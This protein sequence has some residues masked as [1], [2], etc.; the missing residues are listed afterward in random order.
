MRSVR[1][2][3][4]MKEIDFV[5]PDMDW[6][7]EI[8]ERKNLPLRCSFANVH[9]C[10]RYYSSLYLLGEAHITTKMEVKKIKELDR[11]WNR[12]SD[13]LPVIAEHDTGIT[14]SGDKTL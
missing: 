5:Y 4:D 7:S 9:R 11:L 14:S 1:S 13:L 12:K 3:N 10:P 2:Q 6:Y 8:S